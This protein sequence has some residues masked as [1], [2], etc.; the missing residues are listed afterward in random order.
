MTDTKANDKV[1][2]GLSGGVDSTA[3]AL[4]L[5]EKGFD[6]TGLFFDV[7]GSQE[8]EAARAEKAA[9]QIGIPFIYKDVK[10]IFSKRVI[11]YFCESYRSGKTPNPC[12]FCNPTVKFQILKEEADR[13]GAF[14]LATGHYAKVRRDET[15]GY[16][17]LLRG[18]NEQKDQSYMMYRLSQTIL[19]RL[20]LPLGMYESKELIRNL[21]REEGIH[22]ADAKDSQEICFIKEGSYIDYLIQNGAVS[23]PGDFVDRSGRVLGQ[24]QGM[25]HY[26]VGQRKGLGITFGKPMFVVGLDN[27]K[28]QVILG[29]QDE[30]FSHTVH[31]QDCRFSICEGD[32]QELP[33]EYEGTRVQAKIRYAASPAEAIVYREPEGGIRLEFSQPQ[34]AATPG[35]SVV[36]YDKET[37]LGGGFIK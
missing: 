12:V 30:L 4:L 19:S 32:W 14:Y 8:M 18:S 26:T 35:Q 3:A 7:L 17:H 22:N 36:F 15:T 25:I 11:S 6:V 1:V 28:N 34:R 20:I 33:T 27:E 10:E 21:V 5:K 24:H 2:L 29:G 13:I 23:E 37:L 16:Y 31:A 9:Q